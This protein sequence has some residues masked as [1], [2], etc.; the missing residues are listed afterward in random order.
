[1]T[2]WDKYPKAEELALEIYKSGETSIAKICSELQSVFKEEFS[3]GAVRHRVALKLQESNSPER[4]PF[5]LVKIGQNPA[6]RKVYLVISDTHIP[7]EL[8]RINEYVKLFVGYV[9][10]LIIAGDFLDCYCVSSFVQDKEISL[11]EEMILGYGYLKQWTEWFEEV[12][13][14]K[15]NHDERIDNF[16][17]KNLKPQVLF[18]IPDNLA[19]RH[20]ITGFEIKNMYGDTKKYEGLK[21]LTVVNDW[22]TK[23]G[24]VFIA[25]PKNF[26]RVEGKTAVMANNYFLGQR[27]NHRGVIIGHTHSACKFTPSGDQLIM[28]IGCNCKPQD[29]SQKGNVNYRPQVN[30]VAVLTLDNGEVNINETNYFTLNHLLK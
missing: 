9:N 11:Q 12:I 4:N 22:K 19:L 25:H 2:I 10:G 13:M 20:Y 26:S 8:T 24:D 3:Y 27:E 17:R 1:M 29:Y 30:A 28:E 23:V 15:G 5:G 18:L 6:T 14:I 16:V 7:F 21:H